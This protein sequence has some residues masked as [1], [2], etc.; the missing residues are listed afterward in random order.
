LREN[1]CEIRKNSGN[2]ST[3]N[4]D[5]SKMTQNDDFK[6]QHPL[7]R[8][9]SINL[10]TSQQSIDGSSNKSM[11]LSLSELGILLQDFKPPA[12]SR[13]RGNQTTGQD[14]MIDMETSIGT[15]T[16]GTDM[17]SSFGNI[18]AQMESYPVY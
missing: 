14:C 18:S 6:S 15:F 5:C 13:R 8:N 4:L 1:A 7:E 12:G 11:E 16:I 3:R 9:N 17:S 2:S 10:N